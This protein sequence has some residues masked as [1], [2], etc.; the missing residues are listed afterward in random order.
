MVKI[1]TIVLIISLCINALAVL[2]FTLIATG[3]PRN[4]AQLLFER[5][6]LAVT[7]A[8]LV[9]TPKNISSIAFN[10]LDITLRKGESA[11]LQFSN[12]IDGR[13][14]NWVMQALYDHSIIKVEAAQFGIVIT[15]LNEGECVMQTITQVGITDIAYIRVVE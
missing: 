8:M 4:A 9:S 15:A 10:S 2:L 13:Q 12:V 14:T 5:D 6:E 1:K 7:H 3:T 11:T